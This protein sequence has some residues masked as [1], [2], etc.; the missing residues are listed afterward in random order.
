MEC[1]MG[2][3][4]WFSG[5]IIGILLCIE[6][7]YSN[8]IVEEMVHP[9]DTFLMIIPLSL[10]FLLSV[11]LKADYRTMISAFGVYVAVRSFSVLIGVHMCHDCDFIYALTTSVIGF[12]IFFLP[13]IFAGYKTWQYLEKRKCEHEV[14]R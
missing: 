2:R 14:A 10:T 6:N 7:F 8:K 12:F 4:K 13:T 3:M 11:L 9:P 1:I 5:I